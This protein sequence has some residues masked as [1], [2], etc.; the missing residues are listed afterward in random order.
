MRCPYCNSANDQVI[1]SRPLDSSSVIRRRRECLE[2]K[3]RFTTYERH[4]VTPLMVV[5]SD[6]RREPFNRKKLL[7]GVMRACEKRPISSDTIEK[8]VSE[9]EYELQDYVME[10]ESQVIGEKVLKRLLDIDLIAYIR[11]SSVYKQFGDIDTFLAELKKLK[12]E[13][14][15]KKNKA[16]VD[17]N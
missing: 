17:N 16:F 8:I 3:K 2:C 10:V 9:V 5:K 7:D 1:D 11:F 14:E 15:Q 4:E 6:N 12:K 13:N